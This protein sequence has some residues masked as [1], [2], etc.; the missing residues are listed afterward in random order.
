[1]GDAGA[2][3]WGHGRGEYRVPPFVPFTAVGEP[4][5]ALAALFPSINV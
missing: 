5:G 3:Q 2:G 4:Q 1:M